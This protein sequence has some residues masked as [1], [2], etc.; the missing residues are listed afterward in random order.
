MGYLKMLNNHDLQVPMSNPAKV[1]QSTQAYNK[2]EEMIVTL[3]LPPGSSFTEGELIDQTG[4]GR[5]PVR[6]AL[7]RLT[8]EKLVILIPRKGMMI[9]SIDIGEFLNL[10]QTRRVL[11]MLLAEQASRRANPDQRIQIQQAAD[12]MHECITSGDVRG[13]LDWDYRLDQ[14]V[15]EAARNSYAADAVSPLY[16][17]CRRFWYFYQQNSDMTMVAKEHQNLA[18]AI[19]SA[20]AEE[21]RE[22]VN[23]LIQ[24]WTTFA[25]SL[26]E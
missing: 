23:Q 5:T 13:F 26:L 24:Y 11:D 12:N 6:E 1:S 2:I 19:V 15:A 7:Q 10:L 4:L 21:A 9:S 22:S 8:A 18:R 20:N 17:H 25:K 14:I 16:T 3:K